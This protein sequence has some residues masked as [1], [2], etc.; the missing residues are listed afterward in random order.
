MIKTAIK[1]CAIASKALGSRPFEGY[2]AIK[3]LEGALHLQATDG[4]RLHSIKCYVEHDL[5]VGA[6]IKVPTKSLEDVAKAAGKRG[7]DK[8]SLMVER[9]IGWTLVLNLPDTTLTVECFD[10][11]F[12]PL[13]VCQGSW[14]YR[15][16]P[17]KVIGFDTG[18]L[19]DAHKAFS[20]LKPIHGAVSFQ[21]YGDTAGTLLKPEFLPTVAALHDASIIITPCRVG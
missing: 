11:D 18:L 14:A 7:I 9:H 21:F 4:S 3:G 6:L 5:P 13:H 10:T 17:V 19:A 2:I 20:M 8:V 15:D 12:D 16:E 1:F